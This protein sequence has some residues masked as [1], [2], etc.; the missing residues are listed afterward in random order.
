MKHATGCVVGTLDLLHNLLSVSVH[1]DL[2]L[3][4]IDR[5][6]APCV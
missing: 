3:S 5:G 4:A 1:P 6:G 2:P